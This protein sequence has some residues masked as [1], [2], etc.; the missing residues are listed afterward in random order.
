MTRDRLIDERQAKIGTGIADNYD[1]TAIDYEQAARHNASGAARLVSSLPE[2]DVER[3]LDIGCGTGFAALPAIRR[4]GAHSVTGVDVS[5]AMLERFREHL[6]GLGG[7]DSDLRA[8]SEDEVEL[9]PGEFDLALSSMTFH[10]LPDRA[11]AVARMARALRP[12]G[13][14]GI[15]APGVGHDREYVETVRALDP[16]APEPCWDG[17]GLAEVSPEALEDAFVRAGLEVEDIWVEVRVRRVPLDVLMA[18]IRT[19]GAHTWNSRLPEHEVERQLERIEEAA[20]AR[21]GPRGFEYTFTKTFAVGRKRA[22]A[23]DE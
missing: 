12:G 1:R 18:R 9:A 16:P 17:W 10:W 3:I 7:I 15:L 5:A 4:Y 11:G 23:A 21:S 22:P 19:V 6:D 8:G 20:G 13:I 2:A 14:I